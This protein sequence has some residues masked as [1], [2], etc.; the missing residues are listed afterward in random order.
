M[1]ITSYSHE[2]HNKDNDSN[3]HKSVRRSC[4]ATMNAAA[5]PG[6]APRRGAVGDAQPGNG[7]VDGGELW[8]DMV[9]YFKF[10]IEHVE[11]S[12]NP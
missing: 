9:H 7:S 5:T 3:I 4:A 8:M 12:R 1:I 11:N 10:H 6:G 2:I